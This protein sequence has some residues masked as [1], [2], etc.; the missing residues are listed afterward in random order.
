MTLHL[1]NTDQQLLKK[2]ADSDGRAYEVLFDR[3][4]RKVYRL[5]FQYVKNDADAADI[6]QDV[7]RNIWEKRTSLRVEGLFEPYL[8]K[9]SKNQIINHFKKQHTRSSHEVRAA[10]QATDRTTEIGDALYFT[11]LEQH[12]STLVSQL[13]NSCQLVFHLHEDE[14]LSNQQIA[15]RLGLS[16]KTVEY[17]LHKARI[18]LKKNLQKRSDHI[19]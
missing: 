19:H 16:I 2:I 3:Y 11:R 7:F 18:F 12:Y 15:Q 9:A 8:M 17:H 4:W 6:T 5:C 14:Q 13:S 10:E 1:F